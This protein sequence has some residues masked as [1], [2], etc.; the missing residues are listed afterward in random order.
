M[1]SARLDIFDSEVQ[2]RH[3]A[4]SDALHYQRLHRRIHPE[5]SQLSTVTIQL[6]LQLANLEALKR[7]AASLQ[8]QS[9]SFSC[10]AL[11]LVANCTTLD[12]ELSIRNFCIISTMYKRDMTSI[13]FCQTVPKAALV[14]IWQYE[15]TISQLKR[16][17]R[18]KVLHAFQE[19]VRNNRGDKLVL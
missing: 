16:Y 12:S 1:I 6:Y 10:T 3:N 18:T 15:D 7:D 11:H 14:E 5:V 2:R 19:N 17:R 13:S 8:L 9:A 4:E